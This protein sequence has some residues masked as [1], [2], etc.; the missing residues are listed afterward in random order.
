MKHLIIISLFTLLAVSCG[1]KN[2]SEK[3]QE[4]MEVSE[5]SLTFDIGEMLSYLKNRK[6]DDVVTISTRFGEMKALL[7]D[8]TPKHKENFLKLAKEGFFN[9]T[10]FHRV[11]KD[12]MIQGGDPNSKDDNPGNDGQGGPGYTIEAE[13][14]PKFFHVKGALSA[15][16]LGDGQN[17]QKRSSGSQFYIVQGKKTSIQDLEAMESSVK[18]QKKNNMFQSIIYEEPYKEKLAEIRAAQK[19]QDNAKLQELTTYFETIVDARLANEPESPGMG[20]TQKAAYSTLGGTPHLDN[21]YTVFG[22]VISGLEIVDKIADQPT[23][24]PQGSTPNEKIDIT[25]TVEEMSVRKIKKLAG[26]D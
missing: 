13:F 1:N 23:G 22:I 11:I 20:L 5:D 2:K 14:N 24:G 8:E 9:G 25:V 16:R 3:Q 7:F 6:K 19:A 12:F 4:P 17:P 10:T 26:I 15:A 18:M 21:G